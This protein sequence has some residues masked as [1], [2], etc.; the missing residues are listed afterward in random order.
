[1]KK[2]LTVL[3]MSFSALLSSNFATAAPQFDRDS[4]EHPR[5]QAHNKREFRADAEE[6]MQDKRRM[7][8]ERTWCET[9]TTT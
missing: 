6:R 8:E 3:A 7:R 4:A 2:I 1:M 5:H 9:L